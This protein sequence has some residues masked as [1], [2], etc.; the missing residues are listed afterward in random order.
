MD[1]TPNLFNQNQLTCGDFYGSFC[2]K[3]S[4]HTHVHILWKWT[5]I[6]ILYYAI[7][8]P[9]VMRL[10]CWRQPSLMGVT[11]HS[12]SSSLPAGRVLFCICGS[13]W[14]P[15]AT[16]SLITN[17]LAAPASR[18][19]PPPIATLVSACEWHKADCSTVS[20]TVGMNAGYWGFFTAKE[21]GHSRSPNAEEQTPLNEHWSSW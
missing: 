4:T 15:C 17:G 14:V 16:A 21:M 6:K 2:Q 20:K 9:P 13:S 12:G 7:L 19:G 10:L 1:S 18:D 11:P 5:Q 3:F 8:S